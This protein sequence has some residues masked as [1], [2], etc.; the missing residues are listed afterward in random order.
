M[1][2]GASTKLISIVPSNGTT[3]TE[4]QKVEFEIKPNISFIKG[5]DSYLS[6][7]IHNP[8]QVP[9]MFYNT[10]GGNSIINRMDIYSLANGQLLE[11][12]TDYSMWVI[13]KINI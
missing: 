5:R 4:Q 6:F 1:S 7:D 10:V 9:A 13:L 12:L 2:L 8:S 11:S 3:F